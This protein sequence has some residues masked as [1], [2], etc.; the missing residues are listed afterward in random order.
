[1]H[2]SKLKENINAMSIGNIRQTQIQS[3]I[4]NKIGLGTKVKSV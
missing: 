3:E 1:M 4:K 2:I